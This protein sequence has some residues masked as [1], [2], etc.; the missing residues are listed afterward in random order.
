MTAIGER[1]EWTCGICG[2]SIDRSH[3]APHPQSPSIDHIFPVSLQGA[4]APENAQITH[5]ICN[6]LKGEEPL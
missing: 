6:A 5:L 3:V 4:H 2:E 1:D